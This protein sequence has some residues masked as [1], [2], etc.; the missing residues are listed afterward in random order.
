MDKISADN[1]IMTLKFKNNSRM[2]LHPNYFLGGVYYQ[3][4]NANEKENINYY[5]TIIRR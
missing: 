5:K 1:K 4:K 2:L 3:D